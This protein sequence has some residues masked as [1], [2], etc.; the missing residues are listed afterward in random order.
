MLRVIAFLVKQPH[1]STDE[2]IDYYENKH[3]PLIVSLSGDTLPV[4][5]K[6]RYLRKEPEYLVHGQPAN[7]DVI[8]ELVFPDR[9]AQGAWTAQ[10][11]KEGRGER[12]V[13]D[14]ENFLVRS[15]TTAHVV[16]EYVTKS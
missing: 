4:I 6:R 10:L 5:Y 11:G 3:V 15:K 14:E 7:F 2:F 8:T 1:L 12:I 13:A 9:E 16:E